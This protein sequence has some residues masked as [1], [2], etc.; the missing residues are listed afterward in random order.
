MIFYA[1]FCDYSFIFVGVRF[2][3]VIGVKVNVWEKFLV[4]M[5]MKIIKLLQFFCFL[6]ILYVTELPEVFLALG[7]KLRLVLSFFTLR[8]DFM[9]L[10]KPLTFDEQLDKLAAH[11]MIITDREKAKDILKSVNYYRFTGYALQFRQ[12]PSGSDYILG[13]TFETVYHLYKVDEILCDTFRRYIEKAEVYY[14]TQIAYGFSIAKCTETPYDQHY[15][16]NNF[17]NKK[18]YRE[19]MENFSREKNYYK[20]SLIV[21]HHKMKYSSKMPLWVIV[22]LM[23]F[24][25]MSKLY[26]SMY[27]SE[28]DAIAH[29]V[30]VGR[31]TLENHLHC[32]SVLRNKCAHAARM[33]NT[34]FNPPAKFTTSFLRKHPEIKNNSLFAYTLVLL[35][36]LPDESSKKSLIQ[37]VENVISEYSDDIDLK[38]IG[39]PEN[40]MEIMKNNL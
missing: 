28:K 23:S 4:V 34:D 7:T 38:L 15:D 5:S 35:K 12:A 24:S 21:K 39:F 19:V 40:Y 25:N 37:T 27:Y 6:N 11:G 13:T 10:K 17:Y 18:G 32:L 26:S 30:G 14:R 31:D 3:G 16:E 2:M 33:Y 22:E 9:D 36:R 20:D 8:R 1:D 29:M